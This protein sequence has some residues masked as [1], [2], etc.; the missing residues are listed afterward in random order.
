MVISNLFYSFTSLSAKATTVPSVHSHTFIQQTHLRQPSVYFGVQSACAV[1]EDR[2]QGGRFRPA[3][4]GGLIVEK[5]FCVVEAGFRHFFDTKQLDAVALSVG[6]EIFVEKERFHLLVDAD[7][8]VLK[9]KPQ[10][11]FVMCRSD[12]F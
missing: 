5:L 12:V 4:G 7:Q 8:L 9:Q 6:E 1:E 11:L 3:G 2:V 10:H